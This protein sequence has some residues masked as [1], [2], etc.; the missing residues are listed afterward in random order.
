[1]TAAGVA[2]H[3]ADARAV[4]AAT[5]R[6]LEAASVAHAGVN[7]RGAIG[8]EVAERLTGAGVAAD[9]A[10]TVADLLRECEAARF[11]PDG[12]DIAS[13]R[14]RWERARRAIRGLERG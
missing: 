7:V 13:A 14:D 3:G 11:S 6:A 1:M 9:V 10:S 4:D 8:A 12:A 5:A 2:S